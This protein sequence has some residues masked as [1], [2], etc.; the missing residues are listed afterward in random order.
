MDVLSWGQLAYDLHTTPS[1]LKE[2][3]SVLLSCCK[4]TNSR[5]FSSSQPLLGGGNGRHHLTFVGL[6]TRIF[7][8][9][10]LSMRRDAFQEP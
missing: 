3:P 6:E 5:Y 1:C 7:G 4:A 8:V 2:D 9:G 10:E